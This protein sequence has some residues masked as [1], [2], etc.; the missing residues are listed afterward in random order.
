MVR[1]EVIEIAAAVGGSHQ[2]KVIPLS[3][4]DLPPRVVEAAFCF[5]R[6]RATR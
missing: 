6:V 5:K 2:P 4:A 1:V 3:I